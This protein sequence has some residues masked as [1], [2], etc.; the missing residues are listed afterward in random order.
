MVYASERK[1]VWC[2]YVYQPTMCKCKEKI[3]VVKRFSGGDF[4]FKGIVGYADSIRSEISG[5]PKVNQTLGA[6]KPTT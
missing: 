3:N 2:L 4:L 5:T 6:P 1:L